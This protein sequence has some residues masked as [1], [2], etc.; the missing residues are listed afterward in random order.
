MN[1]LILAVLLLGAGIALSVSSGQS[2][3][4]ATV[5]EAQVRDMPVMGGSP[6]VDIGEECF[7]VISRF[8]PVGKTNALYVFDLKGK[9]LFSRSSTQGCAF[10]LVD[11]RKTPGFIFVTE[12][13]S[14]GK[15][16]TFVLDKDGSIVAE[17]R[18]ESP[19]QSTTGLAYLYTTNNISFGSSPRVYDGEGRFI[20]DLTPA[21]AYWELQA[22]D[23]S[24]LLFH[25]ADR[26]QIL[27][28]PEM[29]EQREL[30][31]PDVRPTSPRHTAVSPNGSHYAFRSLDGLVVCNLESGA[32]HVLPHEMSS[33]YYIRRP[34][35]VLSRA[36]EYVLT[37]DRNGLC[38]RLFRFGESGYSK[39]ADFTAAPKGHVDFTYKTP[40]FVGPYCVI[41]YFD[42]SEDEVKLRSYQFDWSKVAPGLVNGNAFDGYL[43]PCESKGV[44]MFRLL[45]PGSRSG[46][47]ASIST[48]RIE[49]E[50]HE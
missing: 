38:C 20:A 12:W 44:P 32:M 46:G 28:V 29:T 3:T 5:T 25:N 41:N 22:L 7:A 49:E 1:R 42:D 21:S 23:D 27:K 10:Y 33:S 34:H 4:I 35:S 6:G 36:G 37:H 26:I 18:D 45:S 17:V 19:V 43:V 39:V 2:S 47:T 13:I 48:V 50:D 31:L 16:R 24:L 40:L 8:D 9:L 15:Y 14:E 11:L 30:Q